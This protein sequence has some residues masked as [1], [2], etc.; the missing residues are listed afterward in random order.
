VVCRRDGIGKMVE[1]NTWSFELGVSGGSD[2]D[3]MEEKE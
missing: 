1:V 3:E 2:R